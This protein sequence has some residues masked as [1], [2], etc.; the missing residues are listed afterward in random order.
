VDGAV[1]STPSLPEQ[2]VGPIDN[3]VD[4]RRGRVFAEGRLLRTFD[5]KFEFDFGADDGLKDAYLE[6][7]RYT[8]ILRWR[9]GSFREPFSLA[10]HTSSNDLGFLEWPLPVAA[11]APGRNYGLMVRHREINPRLTWAASLTTNSTDTD[12]NQGNS[13]LTVTGRIT[14]LPVYHDQ[15]RRLIHLGLAYSLRSPEGDEFRYRARP[16]ARFAPFFV[17][18]GTFPATGNSLVGLEFAT[19][20]GPW[21]VQAE[22]IGS[23]VSAED[24]GDPTFT[25]AYVE[26]GWFFT[27]ESRFYQTQDGTFGRL[28]PN[29]LFRGGNPFD[30]DSNG[31]A[32]GV[33]LRYSQ[34][35]LSDGA[36]SGGELRN[37][38]LG[39]NWYLTSA[40]RVLFNFIHSKRVGGSSAN[41]FL[42]RYQFNP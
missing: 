4:L 6:G 14:G 12:D 33:T 22:G 29:R 25:G 15:G 42:L 35:D 21:W 37:A 30:L 36:I 28:Q 26:A 10:R 41:L 27:G 40:S 19:V 5:F 16:E 32:L 7:T 1:A 8:R 11:M 31:G 18:T 39:L 3:G 13:K 9:I 38:S 34:V 23:F 20:Q 17:D 24:A 2:E